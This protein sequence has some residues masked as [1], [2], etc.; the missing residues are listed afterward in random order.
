MN[1]PYFKKLIL[2]ATA[3]SVLCL[4]PVAVLAKLTAKTNHDH[5]KVNFTYH[6]SIV[7]VSGETDPGTDLVIKITSPEGHQVLRRK[8]KVAGILWMNVDKLTFEHV[9]NVYFIRSTKKLEDI[10]TPEELDKYAIGYRALERQAEITPDMGEDGKSRW[11]K[12]LVKYK[13]SSRLFAISYGN[14]S[15]TRK[16]D[17]EAYYTE[18]YWPYEV[19]PGTYTVT[20]Y[21]VKD[22]KVVDKAE[23]KVVV[24]Q[25]G[26]V[27]L[28]ADMAKNKGALYGVLSIVIALA[29]GFG[30]GMV[31]RKGGGAH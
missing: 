13:E 29:A 2:V 17:G 24:E 18:M 21:A 4:F 23:A 11:F 19:P 9:P 12:E 16:D 31:F 15:F 30:V 26:F 3:L 7:S 20:V 6:G 1:Y 5:I 28:L 14:I 25:V 22:G 10:L 8:D 27:K